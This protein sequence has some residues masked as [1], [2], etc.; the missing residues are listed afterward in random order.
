RPGERRVL[1]LLQREWLGWIREHCD[2]QRSGE[3]GGYR[4]EP[5]GQSLDPGSERFADRQDLRLSA[6]FAMARARDRQERPGLV[7]R[8][9][10]SWKN[11][12]AQ[13]MDSGSGDLYQA[14][15]DAVVEAFGLS[16]DSFLMARSLIPL[17][18]TSSN[19]WEYFNSVPL[20]SDGHYYEPHL[21]NLFSDGYGAV[22]NLI[23]PQFGTT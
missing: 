11:R 3:D 5:C 22:V 8:L 19:L 7:P 1:A 23:I 17:G 9:G 14:W 10:T 2:L 20:E 15:Y 12:E 18:S 4:H 16:P 21:F 13:A 6:A